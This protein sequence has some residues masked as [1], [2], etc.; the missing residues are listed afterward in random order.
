MTK[1][2]YLG[3]W[4]LWEVSWVGLFATTLRRL[5]I[6]FLIN[7]DRGKNKLWYVFGASL[8]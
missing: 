5:G 8:W 3:P 2:I 1:K 6:L 4:D 7:T